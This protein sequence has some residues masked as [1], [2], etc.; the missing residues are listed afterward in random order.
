VYQ[1]CAAARGAGRGPRCEQRQDHRLAMAVRRPA[2][3]AANASASAKIRHTSACPDSQ[4]NVSRSLLRAEAIIGP[5]SLARPS[6]YPSCQSD[7]RQV[8]TYLTGS[9]HDDRA[10]RRS[11]RGLFASQPEMPFVVARGCRSGHGFLRGGVQRG[12]LNSPVRTRSSA[13]WRSLWWVCW[14]AR[15]SMSKACSLLTR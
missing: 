3:T 2:T 12:S 6:K 1:R 9:G 5:S 10:V 7:M 8:R 4:R 15:R 14:L 11:S 13:M